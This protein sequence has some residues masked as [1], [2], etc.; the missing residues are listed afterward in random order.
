MRQFEDEETRMEDNSDKTQEVKIAAVQLFDEL[1][2][3]F[4]KELK[5]SLMTAKNQRKME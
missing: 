4:D 3:L 2:K 5:A 1:G